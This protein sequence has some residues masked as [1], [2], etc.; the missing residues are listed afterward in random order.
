MKT[1][2]LPGFQVSR[3]SRS[4]Y[5]NPKQVF[6]DCLAK[7]PE[8]CVVGMRR[9]MERLE[10]AGIPAY[11]EGR[12]VWTPYHTFTILLDGRSTRWSAADVDFHERAQKVAVQMAT[13]SGYSF[14]KM[15]AKC[16]LQEETNNA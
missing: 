14:N 6:I 11:A 1:L 10:Q 2:T 16:Y 9:E 12:R 15:F 7:F 8:A 4:V 13:R 3:D 5:G